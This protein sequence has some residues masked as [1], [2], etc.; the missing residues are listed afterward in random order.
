MGMN[1]FRATSS[2][3]ISL[4][5]VPARAREIVGLYVEEFGLSQAKCSH[6]AGPSRRFDRLVDL[7]VVW[8]NTHISLCLDKRHK[9]LASPHNSGLASPTNA[10]LAS[11]AYSASATH[12]QRF[13]DN[14]IAREC[15]TNA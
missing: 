4:A 3:L 5:H 1:S 13:F 14:Q 8:I 10:G 9:R 2:E 7:H 6:R 12:I 15:A 11:G